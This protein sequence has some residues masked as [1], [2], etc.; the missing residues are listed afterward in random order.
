[1]VIYRSRREI[2]QRDAIPNAVL[3]NSPRHEVIS[4]L[5]RDHGGL[6]EYLDGVKW[7]ETDKPE[8]SPIHTY[9]LFLDNRDTI[10]S[11]RE[12]DK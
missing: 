4:K 2:M 1:M 7:V 6:V 12:L 8:W 3:P 5:H 11:G 9:R 10:Y